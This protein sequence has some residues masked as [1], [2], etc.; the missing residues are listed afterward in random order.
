MKGL[1]ILLSFEEVC[2]I[3]NKSILWWHLLYFVLILTE[4][5]RFVKADNLHTDTGFPILLIL[6]YFPI[7]TT[8]KSIKWVA[9]I[10]FEF[11]V[12]IQL[13]KWPQISQNTDWPFRYSGFIEHLW[14]S[15]VLCAG[16]N[17]RAS[18]S[19]SIQGLHDVVRTYTHTIFPCC[20]VSFFV[21][22]GI[23]KNNIKRLNFWFTS[24]NNFKFPQSALIFLSLCCNLVL[25]YELNKK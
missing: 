18:W 25:W 11:R 2:I 9:Y 7:P 16:S 4:W 22:P 20:L 13:C 19:C 12:L 6:K 10:Y 17:E 3:I 5:M 14:E 21:W 1:N 8:V 23:E 24:Q 15:E